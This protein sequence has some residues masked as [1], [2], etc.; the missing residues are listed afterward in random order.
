MNLL[1]NLST[2]TIFIVVIFKN[3]GIKGLIPYLPILLINVWINGKRNI[4]ALIVVFILYL[5]ISNKDMRPIKKIIAIGIVA[6]VMTSYLNF[7]KTIKETLQVENFSRVEYYRDHTAKLC[8]YSE[9]YPE[10][11]RKY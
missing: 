1:I 6:L 2:I 8:I 7:Y 3:K 5:I 10:K 9:L 11:K 4:V